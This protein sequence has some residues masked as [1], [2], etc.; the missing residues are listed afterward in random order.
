[1]ISKT[2]LLILL[3]FFYGFVLS[4]YGMFFYDIS[5]VETTGISFGD[6]SITNIIKGISNAPTLLNVV[7]F[8]PLFLGLVFLIVSSFPTFN[9]GA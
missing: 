5:S 4:I 2:G 9:G 3:I 8:T 6:I 7:I 1:M